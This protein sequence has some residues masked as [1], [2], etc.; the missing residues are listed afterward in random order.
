MSRISSYS[1]VIVR[2]LL[3]AAVVVFALSFLSSNYGRRLSNEVDKV[4]SALHKRQK[5]IEQYAIKAL[6]ANGEWT[7]MDDLP[8]DMVIYC[9]R[10]DSLCSWTHQF[11]ISNDAIRAYSFS[12]RLQYRNDRN[13]YSTPLA[14]IGVKEQYVNL[15]SSWYIVNTQISNDFSVKVVTG[16]LVR[17]EY[18][19]DYLK[20]RVNRHLRIGDGFTTESI[21]NDDSAIV[22]G[23]EGEPL[24]SIVSEDLTSFSGVGS[25]L[26]WISFLLLLIAAFLNHFRKHDR[27]SFLWTLAALALVR[28]A[29][30][31]YVNT[32]ANPGEIFSPIYYADTAFFNSL[33]NLL[34]NSTLISLAAYSFFTLRYSMYRKLQ[35]ASR[36][37]RAAAMAGLVAAA[38][39]LVLYCF[40]FLK[41]LALN[42]NINLELFKLSELSLYSLLCYFSYAMLVLALLLMMQLIRVFSSGLRHPSM[43]SWKN[44]IG[45]IVFVA[46]S[47]VVI[48]GLYGREKAFESNRVRTT[49]LAVDRDLSMEVELIDIEQQINNDSFIGVL[50]SVKATDLIRNR[51][52]DRYISANIVQQYDIVITV[53]APDNLLDLRTGAEPVGCFQFYDDMLAQYGVP[54]FTGSNISFINNFDGKTTYLG[55]F[56]FIDA[57]DL[58]VS[59]LFIL[60][61]SKYQNARAGN[62]LELLG[63]QQP[64][65]TYVPSRY[66][67]A[68]YHNGRLVTGDGA[69]SYP[70]SPESF[71]TKEGYYQTNLGGYTHF[72][73][74]ISGEDVVILSHMRQPL[75]T[76]VVSFSYL[77]IFLGLF[78]LLFTRWARQSKQ[79]LLPKHSLRRKVTFLVIGS[80][81]VALL[82]MGIGSVSYVAR[83]N[84]QNT[85]E[86]AQDKLN[87]VCKALSE[88]CQYAMLYNDVLTPELS[89][90]IT[91]VS[92]ISGSDVSLYDTKGSLLTTTKP[93]IYE[94]LIAGKR[95]NHKAFREICLNR[96]TSYMTVESLAGM[97]YYSLYAPLFNA[98]GDMVAIVNI[99]YT[100]QTGD[101]RETAVSTISTIVN[102]YLV[103]LIAAILIGSFMANSI[104]RPLAEIKSKID[105]LAL[106]GTNRHIKYKNTKDELGVLIKSYNNMVD[107]LEES[108]RRLAQQE[109]EQAWKEM[110]RQIA[111]EIKNPLTPMRLSIQYLMRLKNENVPGW[112]EK[113]EKIS[114]SLLEQIDTLSET[115]TE[116]SSFS[117]SFSEQISTVDLDQVIRESA[118]LF[119]NRQNVSV[120][121][122]Q[123]VEDALVEARRSQ[124]SRV[125]V[126]LITNSI[127]AI[128]GSGIEY[129]QIKI[130]LDGNPDTGYVV[131]IEDNGPGVSEENLPKLFTPNFTTKSGGNGLGLAI[132]RN[133]IEQAKGEISYSKSSLGGA[134]FTIKLPA[135]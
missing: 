30:A 104:A 76:H 99:P 114:K 106:S 73:N 88:H 50:T 5:I 28:I 70:V 21:H 116:F 13:V 32:T 58:V 61:T 34:I 55:T 91:Q 6:E 126:N 84:I 123:N 93:E 83:L 64:R 131:M 49:K 43:F 135:Y 7:D 15:G 95:M 98:D 108:T 134:C 52:L 111:H 103:L 12:Y 71:G 10:N 38:I 35:K 97:T 63:I 117:K 100:K 36:K 2:G 122:L 120:R 45:Y 121:Y 118:V 25:P 53:C 66:S 37:S 54:L 110:A 11:P 81:V 16:I 41:S 101:V 69:Y 48:I 124:L 56:S 89:A 86:T 3:V 26:I 96:S 90:A 18:P 23:I 24:F 40:Y 9:Y 75:F 125:F 33:G 119:D 1:K 128:E 8:E 74:K 20:D 129:G 68:K 79:I 105:R 130:T 17:T 31:V 78:V 92:G 47:S 59:R 19:S 133:I 102:I 80:M 57:D 127:Q 82:S 44:M 67:F 51:L 4:G 14:Y 132:S 72:V 85:N 39:L 115:A 94:Q 29:S 62:S 112:E 87:M 77:V 42:S 113:L 60:F 109:R 65:N 22:Y 46:L 27:T 107:A